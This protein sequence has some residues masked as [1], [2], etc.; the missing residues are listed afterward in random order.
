MA[1]TKLERKP[2]SIAAKALVTAS[3]DAQMTDILV[4]FSTADDDGLPV[5]LAEI[6]FVDPDTGTTM[7]E[8]GPGVAVDSVV[9]QAAITARK[10][11]RRL[12]GAVE[13]DFP[14]EP[15]FGNLGAHVGKW[16]SE[17]WPVYELTAP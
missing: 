16:G 11:G 12:L 15:D 6:I 3:E 9:A 17:A 13:P 1:G 10:T 14:W 5:S 8:D 7:R 2:L 4:V